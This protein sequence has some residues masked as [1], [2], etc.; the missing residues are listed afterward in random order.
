MLGTYSLQHV[1]IG[2]YLI[3]FARK[4]KIQLQFT[5]TISNITQVVEKNNNQNQ[6]VH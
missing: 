1:G 2:R 3:V 5:P 4:Q 6:Y